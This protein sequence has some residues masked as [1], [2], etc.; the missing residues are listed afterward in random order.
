MSRR[1]WGSTETSPE[2]PVR[3][4]KGR[5]FTTALAP[6]PGIA[7]QPGCFYVRG[8]SRPLHHLSLNPHFRSN[9]SL[10]VTHLHMRSEKEAP[11]GWEYPQDA[12]CHWGL[13]V[14]LSWLQDL[15]GKDLTSYQS[16]A[17]PERAVNFCQRAD[18][19]MTT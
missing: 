1:R 17:A 13:K 2:V 9:L 4:F 19:S 5:C 18:L 12:S 15:V 3:D 11:L 10:L 16:S 8:A 7:R 14:V 6:L